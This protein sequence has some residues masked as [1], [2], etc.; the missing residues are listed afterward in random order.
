MSGLASHVLVLL[1][2][3]SI[4]D[5]CRRE[6]AAAAEPA[7]EGD[8]AGP[9]QQEGLTEIVVTA[10]EAFESINKVGLAIS[11]LSGDT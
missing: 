10:R 8:S 4:G 5:C 6:T 11:A 2:F 9:S 7:G 1:L 3:S